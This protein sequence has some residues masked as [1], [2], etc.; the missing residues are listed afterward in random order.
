MTIGRWLRIVGILIGIAL[1]GWAV[2]AVGFDAI[3]REFQRLG[4]RLPLI[5]G[6]YVVT[7]GLDTWGWRYA[8]PGRSAAPWRSLFLTRLAGE[9]VNYV[10]PLA[11]IGGEPV[12]AYLLKRNHD[13]PMTEAVTSI[14]IAKTT[15]ALG[16]F[17]F[18]LCG[19]L[20]AIWHAPTAGSLAWISGMVLGV[21][22][23]LVGAFFV[24]QHVGLFRRL[25]PMLQ[26]LFGAKAGFSDAHGTAIDA[27]IRHYYRAQRGRLA[28]SIGF[29]FLGWVAGVVEVWLILQ[30]LG[31]PVTFAQAWIIES[32]WQLLKSGAFLIPANIG[33]QEGGIVLIFL[34]LGLS[35]PTGLALGFVRR[36]RDLVW[37]GSGL[38]V[39][40][41]YEY[42]FSKTT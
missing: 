11:S 7:V 22:T 23:A 26:R 2:A 35:L 32:L 24:A 15:L 5:I 42:A 14:V 4:W 30:W 20:L 38:A 27:S 3:V 31:V 28:L 33:A 29:H 34:G 25:G 10:T 40:S 16:L 1:L 13:V 39:L 17:L 8:F 19:I 18:A 37:A 36:L 6:L 12:K 9:A 41:R 21:L